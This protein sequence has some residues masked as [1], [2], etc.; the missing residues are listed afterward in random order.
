MNSMLIPTY[1]K[2]PKKE[3]SKAAVAARE[4]YDPKTSVRE[5]NPH[6]KNGGSG[7]PSFRKPTNDEDDDHDYPRHGRK[8][9]YKPASR[10]AAAGGWKK[11]SNDAQFRNN[12]NHY[13]ILVKKYVPATSLPRHRSPKRAMNSS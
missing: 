4:Q 8:E 10:V 3:E 13:R 7:L 2:E 1:S 5:L 11:A 6:W 12:V 9:E